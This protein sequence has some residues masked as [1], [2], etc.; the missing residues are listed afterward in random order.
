M[1]ESTVPDDTR[2][3]RTALLPFLETFFIFAIKEGRPGGLPH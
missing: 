3:R 2:T 1:N